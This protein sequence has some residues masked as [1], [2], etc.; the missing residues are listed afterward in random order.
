LLGNVQVWVMD[1]LQLHRPD[2][3]VP[4]EDCAT[5]TGADPLWR[6]TAA[7][8]T[9]RT[10]PGSRGSFAAQGGNGNIGFRCARTP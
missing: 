1:W 5:L 7:E 6:G 4:C 2:Y 3:V 10:L 9:L 8:L